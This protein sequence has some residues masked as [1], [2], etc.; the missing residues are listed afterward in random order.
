MKQQKPLRR[1]RI[2]PRS[3]KQKAEIAKRQE[4]KAELIEEYGEHCMTCQD[5]DRD[6]RG[7]SLSHIIPLS[8]GGETSRKNC[9]T[10]CYICH[11]KYE[12]KPELRN[13]K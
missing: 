10:E 3:D 4:L 5:K 11:D 12:K 9:L 1:S 6:W 13:N 2:K 8:R 7:L